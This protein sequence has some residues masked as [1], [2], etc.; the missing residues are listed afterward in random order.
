MLGELA[1]RLRHLYL[2]L[3]LIGFAIP[4][5]EFVT[6]IAANGIDF[7]ALVDAML[8]NGIARF[9]VWDV[10]ISAI[11]VMVATIAWRDRLPA[12]WPPI[13]ATLLVG[14]SLGLPLLLYLAEC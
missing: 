4:Y 3:C 1:M 9:F 12:V 8:V 6:W 2:V 14:V 7:A 13:A 11:V 5:A 10:V